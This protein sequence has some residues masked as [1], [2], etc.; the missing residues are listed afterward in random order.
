[1][2]LDLRVTFDQAN[3]FTEFA[4]TKPG[5][6]GIFALGLVRCTGGDQLTWETE[7]EGRRESLVSGLDPDSIH[8]AFGIWIRQ[9]S[10][11]RDTFSACWLQSDPV[12]GK[13]ARKEA[14][15]G[16]GENICEWIEKNLWAMGEALRFQF[17]P[18]LAPGEIDYNANPGLERYRR[19]IERHEQKRAEDELRRRKILE[20]MAERKRRR[21]QRQANAQQIAEANKAAASR[22]NLNL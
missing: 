18:G 4:W 11:N 5:L 12:T 14:H 1:M 7:V 21:E 13:I 3:G 22:P 8:A 19:K 9:F 15:I 16:V 20:E 17:L 10:T 6:K 2:L